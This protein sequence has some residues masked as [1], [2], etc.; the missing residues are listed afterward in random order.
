MLSLGLLLFPWQAVNAAAIP[1]VLDNGSSSALSEC[2]LLA[3]EPYAPPAFKGVAT[4]DIDAD[5]ALKACEAAHSISP[6]DGTVGNLLGRAYQA[7]GDFENARHF[8]EQAARAGNAY[9]KANL[10][11]FEIEGAGGAS[12]PEKGLSMLHEAASDGNMLAQYSLG[13]IYREGRAGEAADG[14]KAVSWL[15][16]AADQGH[17]IA[18]YDLAIML[19]E[20]EGV[21][22]EPVRALQWLEKAAAIGDADSMAALGYA[23]EQGLGTPVDFTAAAGW[24]Q[25]AAE[26][27]QI[28]AMTNLGRLYEAGEGVP[29]DDKRA[30]MLYLAA[31][32]AG[33]SVAMANL[34]NF[35]E[36]GRGTEPNPK[37]AG[38]WLSRSIMA[39]NGDVVEHLT[40][41][42]D[43][44]AIEVRAAI[45]RILS[46]RGLYRGPINGAITVEVSEGLSRLAAETP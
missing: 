9:A 11:W 18:M 32:E 38:Y 40:E 45:Q 41:K 1:D 28:D 4:E 34:A 44:F 2:Q 31:A 43:D 37:E 14:H 35:Y 16:K 42:P 22:A 17:A 24:Y 23:F 27:S 6:E 20:G 3:G 13:L 19:R 36:F 39:G 7:R 25:R 30:F 5:A 8:F 26:L 15:T 12:D 10:A 29:A 46:E 21:A 33:H